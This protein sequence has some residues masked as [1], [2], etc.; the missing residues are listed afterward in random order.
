MTLIF[1]HLATMRN[2]HKTEI[3]R[4][5]ELFIVK[6]KKLNGMEDHEGN[7][8]MVFVYRTDRVQRLMMRCSL[9]LLRS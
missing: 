3:K 7:L 2:P 1:L 5:D 6:K 4:G 9:H 8:I